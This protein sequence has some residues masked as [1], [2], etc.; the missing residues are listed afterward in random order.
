MQSGGGGRGGGRGRR[1]VNATIGVALAL[2]LTVQSIRLLRA[3]TVQQGG[4][5]F[6]GRR[7]WVNPDNPARQQA[8]DWQRS[9]A[10]DA[11]VMRQ[12]AAQPEAIWLGDWN[13]DIRGD[14]DN[15]LSRAGGTLPIFVAYNIP[16]RDCGLY[17][18]GGS[19][20][21]DAYRRWVID[22]ARGIRNRPSVVILEPDAVAAADCLPVRLREERFVLLREATDVL[23]KAGATVYI[24]A[25]HAAWKPV[26]DVADR[27]K[28]SGIELA[29]GFALNVSNFQPT[30]ASVTYGN[31]LSRLVNG[32]H[33]VIDTSR[34]GRGVSGS[35]NWCN[36]PGQALGPLPSVNTGSPLADAYLWVKIPGQSDGTCNGGPR[37]GQWW[38][39]Y[40]LALGRSAETL[41]G[42]AAR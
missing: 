6:R 5:P 37:A 1:R 19:G 25:G 41:A 28:K 16:Y 7:L 38:P 36:P 24:D 11:T 10:A 12:M 40:A 17:S 18:R 26:S 33:Y 8:T 14:V 35:A 15:F 32:K 34:N 23:K 22:L 30:S 9:R 27:L 2:A 31:S 21:A 42:V 29:D 39:D 4:N 3:G 20:D 13:R